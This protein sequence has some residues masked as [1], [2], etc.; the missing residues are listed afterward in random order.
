MVVV[1][2]RIEIGELV[3]HG[4]NYH[5][6][7]RISAATEQELSRLI[8]KNGLPK[9]TVY[10]QQ[11]IPKLDAGT[12]SLLS[13]NPKLIGSKLAQSIYRSLEYHKE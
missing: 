4:F 5:D 3:L 6:H 8:R 1:K 12:F 13:K 2:I 10:Q 7:S 9:T 11:A